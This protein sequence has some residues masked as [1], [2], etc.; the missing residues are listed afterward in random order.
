MP[1]NA[2][3]YGAEALTCMEHRKK[4]ALYEIEEHRWAFAAAFLAIFT[5]SFVILAMIGATPDPLS[6]H[7]AKE[8]GGV[9]VVPAP[10]ASTTPELP[11]RVVADKISLDAIVNNP[12]S[13]DVEVL[14]NSLLTGAV[15]YPTSGQLGVDGTVLLF[16]HSSYLPI[17]HNQAYKTFDG[18]QNLKAGDV[19]SV[20][21][22]DKEYRYAVT[23]V[24]KAD[25][26][27]DSIDLPQ[28]GKHLILVTCDSFTTKTS[29]FVVSA[30]FTG[31][32]SLVSE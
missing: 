6:E 25:A 13:T 29:R 20:Y 18:I 1:E 27:Q 5:L 7:Y 32:Y 11:V 21:S 2:E 17:V 10:G 30:D 16:G 15:R 19:V 14:D 12:V 31:A 26:T 22:S 3:V 4:G 23:S 28:T 9:P 8:H 24:R